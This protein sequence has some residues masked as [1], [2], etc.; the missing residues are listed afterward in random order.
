[1]RLVERATGRVLVTCASDDG[2]G[3]IARRAG[4]AA[5]RA[6]AFQAHLA[7]LIAE[8]T[9]AVGHSLAGVPVVLSGM[10]GSSIGWRELPY[11]RL[12]IGLDGRGVGTARVTPVAGCPVL[13]ISGLATDRD[14]LRGEEVEIL[15]VLADPRYA[16]YRERG[17]LILPGTHAKHV[18]VRDGQ[19]TDFCTHMT[20][21]L[22]ALL[23]GQSTLAHSLAGADERL[24]L[25]ALGA[26]IDAGRALPLTRALFGVRARQLLHGVPPTAGRAYLLGLL[27]GTELGGL[28][29]CPVLLCAGGA[30]RDTYAAALAHLGVSCE[31]VDP[32]VMET[33]AV[34]GQLLVAREAI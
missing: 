21:E 14:V 19:V 11:A 16:A 15:G 2:V 26:G 20:G 1:L 5:A 32:A 31:V 9:A 23:G 28:G 34:A 18:T 27:L 10:I 7:S 3:Q 13:F 29:D 25:A 33:A 8:V 4:D 6:D 17:L 24:D 22:F 30:Q 12:P